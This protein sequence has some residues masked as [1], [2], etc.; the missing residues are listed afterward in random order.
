MSVA[1]DVRDRSIEAAAADEPVETPLVV[2]RPARDGSESPVARRILDAATPRFYALG[3]RSVSA[4]VI[5]E[6]AGVTKATFYRHFP[7]KDHLVTAYLLALV[8]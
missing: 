1:H 3:I 2:G 7:T 4:E 5:I 8:E 6:A